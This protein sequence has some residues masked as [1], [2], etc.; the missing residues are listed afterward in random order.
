MS[1][2]TIGA[3]LDALYGVYSAVTPTGWETL[4]G[5][6][7]DL[8][9]KALIVGWDQ[10]GQPAVVATRDLSNIS[11]TLASENFD[12]TNLLT[13]WAGKNTLAQ[14]RDE[15]FAAFETYDNALTA[16][17]S[18]GGAVALAFSSALEYLPAKRTEGVLVQA[19]FT[20]H[21]EMP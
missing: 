20:V 6:D 18:L 14:A 3:A 1:A 10:S 17:L 11:A 13:L 8:P 2:T 12:I 19:R 21:C 7:R 16:D 4:D 5:P 15:L 9:R